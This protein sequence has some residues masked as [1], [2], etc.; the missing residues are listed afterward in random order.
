MNVIK[1]IDILKEYP[2]DM[3]VVA[4]V[5]VKTSPTQYIEEREE[6]DFDVWE[7]NGKVAIDVDG[8]YF[9]DVYYN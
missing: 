2:D 3:E 9:R 8:V 1:L 5:A 4:R 7:R 6:T